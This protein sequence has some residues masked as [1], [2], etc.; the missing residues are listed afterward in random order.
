[1]M[2]LY[3]AFVPGCVQILRSVNGLIDKAEAHC[4]ADSL[5]PESLIGAR[6]APD[7]M[8]FAY[9]VKS[10]AVH[11]IGAIEG[12]KQGRFSPDMT[13][14]PDSFAALKAKTADT[15]DKLNALSAEDV[16]ALSEK[17]LI[18]TIGDKLRWEF[19]GQDF[20]MSFSQPNFYFH[21]TTAYD[22]VRMAG[23]KIGKVDYLGAPRRME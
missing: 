1:M 2:T 14:P 23:L 16:E 12:L 22:I 20:L 5:L 11:S 17:P 10:C 7:M 8:D 19:R 13:T 18:F 6:L 21:A 15:L 9:Q 4:A 3:E